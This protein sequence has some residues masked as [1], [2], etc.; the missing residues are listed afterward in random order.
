MQFHEYYFCVSPNWIISSQKA[1]THS[2]VFYSVLRPRLV[3]NPQ[4]VCNKNLLWQLLVNMSRHLS[5]HNCLVQPLGADLQIHQ[6]KG[7]FEYP[8]LERKSRDRR[9]ARSV[10]DTLP[11]PGIISAGTLRRENLKGESETTFSSR[12]S[13]TNY[14]CFNI[15]VKMC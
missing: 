4:Q 2:L 3:S 8:W 15:M 9:R 7:D 5:S 14:R 11:E 12:D 6:Q 1:G 13:E 10:L